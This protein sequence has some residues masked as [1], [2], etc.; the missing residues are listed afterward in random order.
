MGAG[1]EEI[2]CPPSA[3]NHQKFKTGGRTEALAVYGFWRF[4]FGCHHDGLCLVHSFAFRKRSA[5]V[6]TE[7][8]LKLI[9]APAMTG[10]RSKPKNG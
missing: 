2:I 3:H 8:E 5:L 4:I 7:T 9:A 10:L 6:M 1:F